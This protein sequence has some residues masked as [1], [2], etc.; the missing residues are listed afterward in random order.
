VKF[1]E[2]LT[3]GWRTIQVL[4]VHFYYI[5]CVALLIPKSHEFYN[6]S[7]AEKQYFANIEFA[8]TCIASTA[9]VLFWYNL[10]IWHFLMHV[11]FGSALWHFYLIEALSPRP[12][13]AVIFIKQS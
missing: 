13:P 11:S 7:S 6:L 9:V 5:T 8:V 12:Y 1:A 2:F 10:R 3:P 4:F